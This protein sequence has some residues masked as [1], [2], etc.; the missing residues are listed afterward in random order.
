MPVQ[1]N[2]E[3]FHD[4]CPLCT[5]HNIF[6][7]GKLS[8]FGKI[9]FSTNAIELCHLP[10]LWKCEQ[11]QSCFVQR[12]VDE[13]TA[14]ILYS[15]G[16]AGER[17]SAVAFAHNKPR[18]MIDTMTSIFNSK[19]RVL[20]VGCNTGELLDFAKA[21]GCKTAGLEL[22]SASREILVDKGHSAYSTFEEAQDAYDVITAFDLVEHLYDVPT[23]LNLCH[24][25]LA[26]N[27]KLVI[28]TG[29]IGSL[30]AMLSNERWWYAQY[31][32]HI[33]FPS[34]QYFQTYSGFQVEQWLPSYASKGYKHSMPQLVKGA[35][36]GFLRRK[37]TGLPS[38]GPDHTLVVLTQ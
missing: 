10:E 38:F 32:E 28:L 4:C 29:N 21:L 33:V 34:K 26:E 18:D 9:S 5:S 17:W 1:I 22:S 37:Y 13:A 16:Q 24:E 15:T 2:N 11:C 8:Y 25:K 36:S 27:G 7:K 3:T 30:S 12:I 14:K 20:D 6:P 19:D 23:W 31:P 35:V